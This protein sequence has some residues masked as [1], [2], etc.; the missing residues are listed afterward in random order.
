MRQSGKSGLVQP[1]RDF[2]RPL[3]HRL[4]PWIDQAK[5]GHAFVDIGR[6]LDDLHFRTRSIMTVRRKTWQKTS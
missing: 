2:T 3:D 5:C 1:E 4:Q 6:G